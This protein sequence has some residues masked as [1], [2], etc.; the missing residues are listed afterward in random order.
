M[1]TFKV[2]SA[3]LLYPTRALAEARE[4]MSAIVEREALVNASLRAGLRRLIDARA[5]AGPL[6]AEAEYVSLFDGGKSLSLHLFEHVHGDSR[7][8]GA[9]MSDL[10]EQYRSRGLEVAADELPDFLPLFLEF[11][12]LQPLEDARAMLAEV[13]DILALMQARLAQRSSGYAVVFR[14]LCALA[15]TQLDIAAVASQAA[16]EAPVDLDKEWEEAPVRFDLPLSA[17][18][19]AECGIASAMVQRMEREIAGPAPVERDGVGR[20][21][22]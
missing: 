21:S 4:E 18:A 16:S 12:S 2:L 1:L 13:A 10:I 8:R 22:R 7:E 14:V 19:A 17:D 15:R 20:G 5:D 9:A 3:L 11:L 6:E